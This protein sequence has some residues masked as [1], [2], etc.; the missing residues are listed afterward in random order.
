MYENV[1]ME[2]LTWTEFEA[3]KNDVL[4]LPIGAI[5]QHGPH[6]PLCVDTVLAKEFAYRLA[7]K[8]NGVVAP[9]LSYGYKSKPLSG[10]GPLFPGTIDL[11]GATLQALIMDLI[12]EFVKDGFHKIFIMNAHFEN[13]AFI[14]EAMD[15]ASEKHGADVTIAMSNWWDPM[16]EDTISKV[17][18]EV[19]FPGWAF[20]HAA[21]TETSLMM[22]FAPELVHEDRMVDTKGATPCAYFKYPIDKDA[23]PATGVLASARSSSAARGKIIV[24]DVMPTLVEIVEKCF[25]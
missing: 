13:E 10:G 21:V 6:L 11:N 5:E 18:D 12:S 16:P 1:K 9:V 23:I 19:E 2:N 4:I 15:L 25:K 24:D 14:I 3:K 8:V 7:D 17:F 20:E 22:Y